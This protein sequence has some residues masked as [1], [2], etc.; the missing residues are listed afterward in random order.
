MLM[1]AATV[2]QVLQAMFHVLLHVLFYLWSLL[3]WRAG[4]WPYSWSWSAVK[5][6]CSCWNRRTRNAQYTPPT[7]LSSWVAS[8]LAVCIGLKSSDA[9]SDSQVRL[10][11]G[12]ARFPC[13]SRAFL[14][15]EHIQLP[16]SS[17]TPTQL[18]GIVLLSVESVC[19]F[20]FMSVCL[21]TR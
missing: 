6:Q 20:G 15:L 21:S 5:L 14:Y 1:R 7:Q 17:I 4:G 10:Y 19:V 18:S 3:M 2:M 9:W 13:D 16:S 12:I 8:A 11:R